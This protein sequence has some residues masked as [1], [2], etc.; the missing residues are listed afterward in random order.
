VPARYS[1]TYYTAAAVTPDVFSCTCST[2]RAI[3]THLPL[4]N[5]LVFAAVYAHTTRTPRSTTV[6]DVLRGFSRVPSLWDGASSS[7]LTFPHRHCHRCSPAYHLTRWPQVTLPRYLRCNISAPAGRGQRAKPTFT[8]PARGILTLL[9]GSLYR[10]CWTPIPS[11]WRAGE[12]GPTRA[13]GCTFCDGFWRGRAGCF[14][15]ALF[16]PYPHTAPTHAHLHPHL[17]P[18]HTR[19]KLCPPHCTPSFSRFLVRTWR[20]PFRPIHAPRHHLQRCPSRRFYSTAPARSHMP[21]CSL[22]TRTT[23]CPPSCSNPCTPWLPPG[24][25]LPHNAA[26]HSLLYCSLLHFR[27]PPTPTP[28]PLSHASYKH[29]VNTYRAHTG[30]RTH[31]ARLPPPPTSRLL[32]STTI[33]L[34]LSLS[35][36]PRAPRTPAPFTPCCFLTTAPYFPILRIFDERWQNIHGSPV[37][38]P[39][40]VTGY[41]RSDKTLAVSGQYTLRHVLPLLLRTDNLAPTRRFSSLPTLPRCVQRYMSLQAGARFDIY[42]YRTPRAV[43]RLLRDGCA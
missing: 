31:A 16:T 34:L 36:Y 20:A 39:L 15:F 18:T 17:L 23:L 41:Q 22:L 24:C 40:F 12:H 37:A 10:P 32:P 4:A 19:H 3:Y 2:C 1:V 25:L 5:T 6:G 7:T 8:A 9:T 38:T 21:A 13:R 14:P 35:A 33:H 28:L 11:V 43:A 27:I 26:G 29:S 42:Y 30:L